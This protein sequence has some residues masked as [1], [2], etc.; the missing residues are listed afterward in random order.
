MNKSMMIVVGVAVALLSGVPL[1]G[2]H[3]GL[4][5]F[6]EDTTTLKGVVKNWV[7]SNPHCLLTFEVTG[8]DG[9]ATQWVI[10]LQAPNSIYPGGYRRTTFKPGDAVTV[11][12]HPVRNGRPYG[13]LV[14]SV[15][16][17]G[18]TLGDGMLRMPA[19]ARPPATP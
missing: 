3:S 2:H 9:Q 8:E 5:L 17:D 4:T 1:S 10:E 13:R 7:W 15:P 18:K 16:A 6:T 19:A 12:F 14:S 11:T